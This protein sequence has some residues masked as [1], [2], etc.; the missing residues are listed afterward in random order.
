[1]K[2]K[3]LAFLLLGLFAISSAMAQNKTIT[4]RVVGADDGLPLPGVSVRVKGGTAGT[5]TSIDGTYSLNAPASANVLTF[6]YIGFVAQEISISANNTANARLVTDAKQLSEVVVVGYGTSTR[7]SFTGS[8]AVVTSEVFENRPVTSF[9]KALQ[10]T[11]AGVTVSSV[12]GQPGATSTVRVRGVASISASATPLYVIDGIP[13]TTGDLSQVA[14]TSDVLS[15]INPN[16]IETITVL[17]DASAGSIYGSRAANGVILITTKKGKSG[18]TK[19]T[20]SGNGG[21]SSQGVDKHEHLDATQYFKQYFDYYYNLRTVAGD[22]PAAAALSA[23]TS[24]KARLAVNPYN[25]ANPYIAGGTLDPSAQL[26]YDTDWRDAVINRGDVKN[27]NVSAQGGNDATKFFI[28]GGV[29]DQKGIVLASDF[30]RYS[31][32]INISNQVNK[33]INIGF[34]T[35]L[36]YTDQNTPAGAGGAANPVRFSEVVANVYSLYQRDASGNPV[37][38]P[39]GSLVYNYVNPISQDF[40][41]LG[42]AE[43][44]EYITR[45]ARG[46]LNPYA[47]IGFTNNLKFRTN[48]G[49]DYINNRERLFYNPEHGNG[50]APKGRAE[51][52]TVQDVTV[53]FNN[54]LTYARQFGDHDLTLLV[55]QEA[56]R[57]KYDNI[58]ASTTGFPFD[59]VPELVAGSVPGAPTSFITQKRLSSYFTRASYSFNNK[60]YLQGSFRRDG[61]SVFGSDNRFGNFYSGGVAWRIGQEKFLQEIKWLDELKLRASYGTVGNDRIGR[62]DAQGLY[63]LGN[64]YQGQSGI[65]ST[66]LANKSLRWEEN[67]QT[68]IGV[69]FGL[70]GGRLGGEVTYY[71]KQAKGLLFNRPLSYTTGF[72]SVTTN[73]ASM[74]NKGFDILLTGMPVKTT[75]FTWNTSFNLTTVKNEIKKLTSNEVITG[76]KRLRVGTDLYQFYLRD[77]AGV[78]PADGAPT[79][80]M[81]QLGTDGK[82]NG[83]RITTKTYNL[84]TRYDKGSA[85]PDFTGG[86]T[87]NFRYKRFDFTGFLFYSSGGKIYDELYQALSHAGR[88]NGTQLSPDVYNSWKKA[89]DITNTPRFR[90]TNTDLGDSQ[91]S[92]FLYDGSYIRIKSLT[93]G[94]DLKSD[95]ARKVKLSNARIYLSGENVFTFAKHKGMDPETE[96]TGLTSFDVPNIKTFSLGLNIG[97]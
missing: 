66:N 35:T 38:A 9:E 37:I 52:Y 23:N 65:T 71:N 81:D 49:L 86:M 50:A 90:P 53:T 73:L 63:G 68:D 47:E 28:S 64:N 80:F 32:K 13:I 82:P 67:A 7:Q 43:K 45:T 83:T 95:W 40:N 29:F 15:T 33:A 97:F 20:A 36:S 46:I 56:Y 62:Y 93:L 57:S 75:N 25:I 88:A 39:N 22:S 76:T 26:Y 60:Y 5:T 21:Y 85:L 58:R 18:V 31:G 96:I 92:R 44:D 84:A 30:K 27:I 55:G 17:K 61:S 78:D 74:D 91:S 2:R 54:T 89:G 11:V 70:F 19:F 94:Y 87:N 48:V 72:A 14:T 3:L 6:T 24:T 77:Y 1:M 41:P 51:R 59:G 8:A 16:D 34:N 12:S 79:W 69:E 10:G 42:L 4:G